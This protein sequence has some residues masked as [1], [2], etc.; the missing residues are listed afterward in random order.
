L[1][2]LPE[3][4]VSRIM[5]GVTEDPRLFTVKRIADALDVTVGWLLD[6]KGYVFSGEDRDEL[7]RLVTWGEK[8]LR[9]TQPD[10]GVMLEP[11]VLPVSLNRNRAA[12]V[13]RG[14]SVAAAAAGSWRES[15]GPGID[16]DVEIPQRFVA[17]G[18][19]LVFR[20][21]GASM[22]GELISDG[23]H[24]YVREES[25]ARLARGKIV[26]CV[27]D[28][29]PYVKRLELSGGRIRLLSAKDGFPPMVFDER[30]VE[31]SLV[32]VVVGWSH[33]VR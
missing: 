21:E 28:G 17:R 23:D 8:I 16:R 10:K 4:T 26:V 22:E 24:L 2:G 5:T 30:A 25:D 29:S 3:E 1:A 32:G 6:E 9:A 18:A 31:W 12:R 7:R 13:A 14:R 27:V 15:F 20:A 33:D 11:N 19:N